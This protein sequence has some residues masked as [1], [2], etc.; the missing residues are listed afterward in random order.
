MRKETRENKIVDRIVRESGL[1]GLL[2]VLTERI[3]PTDLQSLLLEAFRRKAA[4]ISPAALLRQYAANRFVRCAN[5][6]PQEALE[7]DRLAFSLLPPGFE[8]LELS[9]VSPLG[10]CS[11]LGTVDQ[12]KVVATIRN[13]EVC[14]DP[15]N[16]LALESAL[17]RKQA[18]KS[19]E[20]GDTKLCASQ[21]V[22][23]AQLFKGP[24]SFAHFRI[25]SLCTA[26][27]DRGNS[28]FEVEALCEQI[29]FY[30][31]LLLAARAAGHKVGKVRVSLTPF[32]RGK[33]ELLENQI[34]A[35]LASKYPE[36]SFVLDLDRE[37]GRGYYIWAGFQIFAKEPE[38]AEWFLIDGGFT[39][40]TEKLMRNRKERLLISGMGT[41]RFLVCF[42]C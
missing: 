11:A 2:E 8:V 7:L 23:R 31:R 41:E 33:A 18:T 40:W 36:I 39:D 21:R 26:G 37:A 10:A 32:V 19:R 30:L 28:L 15:T 25:F 35:R 4:G 5:T 13:T 22:V 9:P 3:T 29:D 12:N 34:I 27:R 42:G 16:V 20:V 6:S 1:P 24:A 14:A 17:R 38:G